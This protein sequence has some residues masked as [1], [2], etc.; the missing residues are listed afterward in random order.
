M[1]TQ[2]PAGDRM[3][4][5]C[6]ES[7]WIS[8]ASSTWATSRCPA[9]P[10][11]STGSRARASL[12]LPDQ[13]HLSSAAGDRRQAGGHGHHR[14]P[15]TRSSHRP[16]RRWPGCGAT[17]SS[18]RRCSCPRPPRRS[19]PGWTRSRT[20]PS[21]GAGAVVVGDLGAGVG[22]RHPQPRLPAAHERRRPAAGRPRADPLLAR[23]GRAPARCGRRSCGRWST[24]PAAPRSFSASPIRRSTAPR[25]TTS[26]SSPT[27][28]SWSATTSAPTSRVHSGPGLTGVL[29]RTGKFSPSDLDGDV[30]PDAVLDSV[31]D[32]PRW[33]A[34]P[35]ARHDGVTRGG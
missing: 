20:T 23:R 13:H 19:S 34:G 8:T 5:T 27:R 30:S 15:R 18:T 14:R 4:E 33:W 1:R 31:A 29:V 16:W 12:P 21:D 9:P 22:L 17:A 28:S 24:P 10:G 11:P 3:M 25:S 32:L 7:C 35:T 2:R 26:A 6:A